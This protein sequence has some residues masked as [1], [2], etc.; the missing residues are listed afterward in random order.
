VGVS[1]RSK[2][3]I[4]QARRFLRHPV[5]RAWLAVGLASFVVAG[6]WLLFTG[7]DRPVGWSLLLFSL[8]SLGSLALD[9]AVNSARIEPAWADGRDLSADATAMAELA[10][11]TQKIVLTLTATVLGLLTAFARG[12]LDPATKAAVVSLI[13]AALLQYTTHASA[14]RILGETRR[15]ASDIART[16]DMVASSLFAFGLIALG[17]ALLAGHS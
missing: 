6:W 9:L 5:T 11:D 8:Y 12:P 7:W 13:A 2:F 4:R 17:A 16:L 3:D 15:G 1:I 10:G 14:A